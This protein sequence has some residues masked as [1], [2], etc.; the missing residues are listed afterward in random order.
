MYFY[1]YT[2]IYVPTAK[3]DKKLERATKKT[4]E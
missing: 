3:I 4:E 1:Y 2:L